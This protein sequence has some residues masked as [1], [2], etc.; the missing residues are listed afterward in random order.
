TAYNYDS[1]PLGSGLLESVV[2]KQ[3]STILSGDE[4]GYGIR[5]EVQTIVSRR[6]NLSA[7]PIATTFTYD[8]L[9]RL[10]RSAGA[11]I[12]A[13]DQDYTPYDEVGN[14]RTVTHVYSDADELE[15]DGAFLYAYD[16]NGN[17]ILRRDLTGSL[18][19]RSFIYDLRGQL[20]RVLDG[21]KQVF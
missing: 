9:D 6:P 21:G 11:Q 13:L 5:N 4:L 2:N 10:E 20:V 19:D 18:V 16:D 8:L 17:Q 3:G 15:S 1:G 7:L 12:P 14:R